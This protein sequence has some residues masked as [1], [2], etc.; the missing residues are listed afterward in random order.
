VSETSRRNFF[1]QYCSRRGNGLHVRESGPILPRHRNP[2]AVM[3]VLPIREP[4]PR[5]STRYHLG[6]GMLRRIKL[7]C[8][9]AL[10]RLIVTSLQAQFLRCRP[11]DRLDHEGPQRFQN[12]KRSANCRIRGSVDVLVIL[13]KLLLVT[14][15]FGFDKF[16]LL[17]IL[18]ASKRN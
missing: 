17:K 13:M 5:N 8:T 18:N 1:A 14:V 4:R 11:G 15:L 16:T 12:S 7:Q 3:P 9:L 10:P 6:T 2:E